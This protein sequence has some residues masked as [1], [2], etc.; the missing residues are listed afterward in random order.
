MTTAQIALSVIMIIASLFLIVVV[1]LQEGAQQGLGAIEGGA[2]TFF[3][4]G[5]ASASDRIFARLTSIVGVI[6]VIAA[7][8][9]NIVHYNA[10]ADH[11]ASAALSVRRICRADC[12][13]AA[14][15]RHD[16]RPQ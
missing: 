3:G 9:L 11:S 5:K 14:A 13:P 6:F 8:V 2:D 10:G 4:K 15:L 16:L 7:I 1:L 12:L